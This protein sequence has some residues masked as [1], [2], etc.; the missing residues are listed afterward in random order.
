MYDFH[1]LSD[2]F[3]EMQSVQPSLHIGVGA[4]DLKLP[5]DEET[6]KSKLLCRYPHNL[7][8]LVFLEKIVCNQSYNDEMG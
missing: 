7:H 2:S 6:T 5:S 3:A 8:V 4:A 1:S